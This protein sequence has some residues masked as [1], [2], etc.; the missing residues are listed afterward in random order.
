V[1][2]YLIVVQ[3]AYLFGISAYVLQHYCQRAEI[4]RSRRIHIVCV[5][6]SYLLMVSLFIAG[7]VI[8]DPKLWRF[9]FLWIALGLGDYAV[10]KVFLEREKSSR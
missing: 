2:D 10:L 7:P 4:P 5:A 3:A 6:T 8:R 9:W 1:L